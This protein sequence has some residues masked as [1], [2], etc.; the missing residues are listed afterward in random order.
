M[1]TPGPEPGVT[2][3]PAVRARPLIVVIA[4]GI[5]VTG[6]GWPGIIG[7]LP[8]NLLL[9]NQLHLPAHKVAEF[10]AIATIAGYVKPLFGL[11]SDAYPLFGTRRRGYLLTGTA[12]AS[13][14]WLAFIVVP[15][16][17]VPFVIVTTL[18][19]VAMGFVSTVVGGLQVEAAQRYGATGR[20]AS[21]RAALEGVMDL[22][23]G[24]VTG[25]LAVR[26]FGWTAVAGA[27]VLAAFLPIA[28]ALYPEAGGARPDTAVW[29]AARRQLKAI[30][31][32]RAMWGATGLLF[33]VYLAPGLQTPML[34]YQQDV[35]KLDPRFM[36]FLQ[37]LGGIGGILGAAA[38]SVLCRRLP[39]RVSV[40]AGI[41]LNAAS[42]LLYLRYDS[43]NA[44]MAIDGAAALLGTLATLPLYDIAARA[45][46]AGSE[47]F[48]FALMMSVRNVAIYALSDPFGSYLYDRYHVGFKQLVW[49]NAG[50]SAAVLLFVPLLPAALLASRERPRAG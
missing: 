16:D 45:T 2:S 9:K 25:W 13:I 15:R 27:C 48:G 28:A 4:A 26:S 23:A 49:L 39:L 11:T 32:S 30:V 22:L 21:L 24:P 46:P 50:S 35:L 44:A 42:T 29:A 18:L 37:L 36:G 40:V 20:L 19:N 5:F 12:L 17:Y 31:G 38:Y 14:F 41:I 47:S 6:F 7:R 43:A 34:Y 3:P 10:W 1:S 33:L 8:F